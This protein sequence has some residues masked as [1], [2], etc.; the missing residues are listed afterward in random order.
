MSKRRVNCAFWHLHSLNNAELHLWLTRENVSLLL[1]SIVEQ[2]KRYLRTRTTFFSL[3]LFYG[4]YVTRRWWGSSPPKHKTGRTAIL[5]LLLDRFVKNKKKNNNNLFK[6]FNIFSLPEV[7]NFNWIQS[8]L[9][10]VYRQVI[11]LL[12]IPMGKMNVCNKCCHCSL[13]GTLGKLFC[14]GICW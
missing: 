9:K 10:R 4:F 8:L 7:N 5:I 13:I 2:L 14:A 6:L 12:V 3:L 11:V 1:T